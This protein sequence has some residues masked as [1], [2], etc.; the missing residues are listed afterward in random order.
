[1]ATYDDILGN[2][3]GTPF[4]KGS[5]EWHEQQQDGSS[6]PPPVKGTQEWAEQKAATAPVVTALKPDITTTP[7]P[8]TKQEGSDGGALSYAELFKKLN[9]YTPPTD[10]ELAKEKKKQKRDQIFA[11]IGDGISALSNL[12]FTTQY[13]PNMYTGKNTMS[14][15]TRVRYDRL[16]KER[17]G[18]EKE[19]YAGLMK[20]KIADEEKADRDRKWQRQLGLDNYNR[21][22]N[23]AKEERDRQMFELNLQ[24]QGNKISASEAEAKRK[25][26]EAKYAEELEKARL[27]TEKAKAKYYNRG[28]SGGM[29]GSYSIYNPN[30]GKTEYFKNQ[31]ERDRRAG[32]LGYDMSPGSS[33]SESSDNLMGNK[34]TTSQKGASASARLGQQE[35]EKKRKA[36]G[37]KTGLGLGNGENNSSGKKTGLGL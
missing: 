24:L 14:E 36:N 1:M 6:V 13:A 37:K 32:E 23:D 17:E 33:S 30:T 31:G 7:P 27:E 12:F 26:I 8:P 35:A 11:A 3:G 29:G 5:K 28:G 18:K 9:P 21:I 10:E 16:M 4:P 22:R 15:R 34:K 2:G 19:Y 20:A 25:G